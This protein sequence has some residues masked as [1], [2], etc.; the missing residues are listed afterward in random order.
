MKR[1]TAIAA[2]VLSTP[3]FAQ[4][5]TTIHPPAAAAAA[6]SKA[7]PGI[8]G[9]WESEGKDYEVNF[10]EKGAGM[11][12]VLTAG[13]TIIETETGIKAEALPDAARTYLQ[14][15]YPGQKI[16]DAARIEKA[17]GTIE[18]EAGI[19]NKDILFNEQ[20]TFLKVAKD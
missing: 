15:H 16:K 11:S 13:G 4:Q 2:I 19:G 6:F 1:F 8:K 3:V 18:Y 5:E 7:H 9:T 10:R 20:G 14:Q 12:C 17:N